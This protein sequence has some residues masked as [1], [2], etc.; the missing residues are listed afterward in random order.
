M[1]ALGLALLSGSMPGA[2]YSFG[3]APVLSHIVDAE[4]ELRVRFGEEYVEYGKRVP[5]LF[6][7]VGIK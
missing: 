4:E 3:L 1:G 2:V 7:N 5:K 6:P